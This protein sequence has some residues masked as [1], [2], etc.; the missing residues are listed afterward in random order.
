MPGTLAG[1]DQLR[2]LESIDPGHS[3]VQKD[4]GEIMIQAQ[5]QSIGPIF[6]QH[7]LLLQWL[8]NGLQRKQIVFVVVDSQDLDL[9]RNPRVDWS[10][11]RR[12]G[13][14]RIHTI[15]ALMRSVPPGIAAAAPTPV[16]Q[17]RITEKRYARSTG[18]VT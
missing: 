3:H 4:G 9:L 18:L 16:S 12:L 1:P 13:N 11:I 10:G 17:T 8:E 2:G 5:P 7:Q 14:S 15:L 6:S